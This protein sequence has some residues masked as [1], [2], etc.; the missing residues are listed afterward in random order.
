MKIINF[1]LFQL[2]WTACVLGAA[3]Q[4]FQFTWLFLGLIIA[5]SIYSPDK[6]D[7]IYASLFCLIG[8]GSDS[9]MS[10]LSL[11]KYQSFI[12]H[13]T[14]AP[15]WIL[16]LWLGMALSI[17]WS[18]SWLLK[19][20]KIGSLFMMVGAPFSYFFAHNLGAIEIQF[21]PE[22]LF[23][24]SFVWGIIYLLLLQLESIPEATKNAY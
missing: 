11:I 20:P 8:Y 24:I 13:D 4:Q 18:F 7:L 10:Y 14:L 1:I 2:L 6:K 16:M 19:Y 5:M 3:Y 12:F 22:T 23:F 21:F 9:L 17:R 15:A